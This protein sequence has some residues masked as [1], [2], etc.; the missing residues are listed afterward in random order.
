MS[1][2][3]TRAFSNSSLPSRLVFGVSL[4]VG[5]F[6][7]L[8]LAAEPLGFTWILRFHPDFIPMA[9]MTASLL[10]LLAGALL[11]SIAGRQI[12]HWDRSF[13]LLTALALTGALAV[14]VLR[15]AGLDGGGGQRLLPSAAMSTLTAV[16]LL[17]TAVAAALAGPNP[18]GVSQARRHASSTLA[19]LTFGGS[20]IVL[21]SYAAGLPLLY[22]TR[23]VPMA[24]PTAV[25]ACLLG[26]ALLLRNGNEAWPMSLFTIR[27][28][29][30]DGAMETRVQRL[31]TGLFA[32][33]ALGLLAGGSLL[34][35]S[36]VE[37]ER[38]AVAKDLRAVADLKVSQ[39]VRWRAELQA[40]GWAVEKS[41]LAQNLLIRFMDDPRT[42]ASASDI[43]EFLSALKGNSFQ[44]VDVFDALGQLRASSDPGVAAP[45]GLHDQ[46]L[47]EVLHAPRAIF[48]DLRL[49]ARSSQPRLDLWIPLRRAPMGPPAGLVRFTADPAAF[50]YPL[51]QSWPGTSPSAETL[52]V[53]REGND[54]LFLNE[55]RHRR[56][57]A[58]RL[59][60]P[61]ADQ[62][63][64]P[65]ARAVRDEVGFITGRDYRGVLVLGW[66]A[67]VPGSS[68]RLV[69][70]LD[71]AEV[72]GPVQRD[73]WTMTLALLGLLATAAL[74]TGHWVQ[75][76]DAARIGAQLALERERNTLAQRSRQL[77]EQARD[78]ILITDRD[79]RIREANAA[80]CVAYG[81]D[82][83]ALTSMELDELA[84]P[85]AAEQQ[86]LELNRLHTEGEGRFETI[87]VDA[88]GH[89]FPVEV[90]A[91]W[92]D[93]EGSP[94][95]L[96]F[97]R[98]IT[99]RRRQEQRI[100]RLTQL[101]AALSQVNQAI[102]REQSRQS[103]LDKVCEVMVSF[104]HFRLAWVAWAEPG[105]PRVECVA[106]H[107]DD[108]GYLRA[109]TVRADDSPEA[110]GPV[111]ES[112]TTDHPSIFNDF[113]GSRESTPWHAEA[114]RCGYGS[115]AAFPIHCEGRVCGS[116]AV[117][118]SEPG[119]FGNEE[120]A[121]LL[122][123]AGDL[124][125]AL[126]HILE[127]QA[128]GAAEE[129]LQSSERFLRE[130]QEAGQLGTYE[131]D[132]RTNQWKSSETM[133]RIFGIGADY[134]R[135]L[136]GWLGLVA[137]SHR[138]AMQAYV[139]GIIAVHGTF[140]HMYPILRPAD[141]RER[142]V[143]GR[144]QFEWDADGHPLRLSGTIQDITER[145]EAEE[146]ERLM[147]AQLAQAQKLESLGKLAGG[148]AHDMNNV[149]GAILSLATTHRAKAADDTPL[150]KALDTIHTA[151]L[152]GRGVVKGLL[153][154]AHRDL[155]DAR[156]I[157]LNTLVTETVN[158]LAYTTLKKVRLEMDLEEDLPPMLGDAGA[159][160]H[161]LMNLCVNAVDAMGGSGSISIRTRRLSDGSFRISVRDTGP[162][163]T[164]EV[165]AKAM[166]PFFT[167][168]PV[169]KG[170]G[171]GLS[172]AF[173][174][175]KAHE[176]TLEILSEPGAGTEI[177]MVFPA[178]RATAQP[179]VPVPSAG[180]AGTTKAAG[181]RILLVDDDELI[182]ESVGPML[183]VMG[184]SV[185]IAP[186]GEEA[187]RIVAAGYDPELVLLDMNM[188]GMNGAETLE[189]LL[190]LRPQQRVLL[191]TG[192]SDQ[193]LG[194]LLDGRPRVGS[195]RK[196]FSLEELRARLAD[197]AEPRG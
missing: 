146:R 165:R 51:I 109:I 145:R 3:E 152:R 171:L 8:A 157:E 96:A 168:K 32:L 111:G 22:G 74:A 158:L 192:Y 129:A 126:D 189:R 184:H 57:E 132:L 193:G 100:V 156:A 139:A 24:L 12:R 29:S 112:I 19:L 42:A 36:R 138:E 104:G 99:E 174:T 59:R 76:R 48:H 50:L 183:G 127:E 14:V 123:T 172:M 105:A 73:L 78:L 27:E 103:I 137:P 34:I 116:L 147:E 135:D 52:L 153:Y 124:S 60:L 2:P 58:L 72:Y 110:R 163:M 142:W 66:L 133:D 187:L 90:N 63:D 70:K 62:P 185:E 128:R 30:A 130:A 54:V 6:A 53:R 43:Q 4:V 40:D 190:A 182:R 33:L 80:A 143:Y 75:R 45:L 140:D 26:L 25:A 41:A 79:G 134:V 56:G 83:Q 177:R 28:T 195:I 1:P 114:R 87:H 10:L 125:F 181:M 71:A 81:R 155:E 11:L 115:A 170:T 122:E 176:G 131:W 136:A 119:F 16:T 162:G 93:V 97:L 191:A 98:D 179:P 194:G 141:G 117:Y 55:L 161:S 21:V 17:L 91:R 151:C 15:G 102:T 49:D 35:R 84:D 13:N 9:P 175:M 186:G 101:Y 23:Q 95:L 180:P 196:P 160:S 18:D 47:G 108:Q 86:R 118:A 148:V 173:G 20:L 68:W 144:G 77:M 64:L 38:R 197:L 39:I 5:S 121:L 113:I 88:D 94:T 85:A 69:A 44:Q 188:P 167:T 65:A 92:I 150:A 46:T 159:I 61:L 89:P 67:P 82:A 106:S 169:G 31:P 37:S 154:F 178:S 164:E 7:L 166:E 120:V 149:L 107:G